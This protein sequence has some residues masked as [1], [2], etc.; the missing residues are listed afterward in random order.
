MDKDG[1]EEMGQDPR[2]LIALQ[3]DQ[4]SALNTHS[5]QLITTFDS[6]SRGSGCLG[7]L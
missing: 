1:A 4:S 3:E 7:P 5:R 6:T 2:A